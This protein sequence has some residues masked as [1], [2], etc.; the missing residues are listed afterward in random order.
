MSLESSMD[1]EVGDSIAKLDK[2][3]E[4]ILETLDDLSTVMS[5]GTTPGIIDYYIRKLLTSVDTH[6]LSE[7]DLM[8]KYNYPDKDKHI[9][10][11]KIFNQ[12][13]IDRIYVSKTGFP[14]MSLISLTYMKDFFK[15]HMATSNKELIT[16]LN[17]IQKE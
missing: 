11:H 1:E 16:F 12:F 17:N 9:A 3:H 13:V 5:R 10:E 2:D 7:Q 15:H 6:F 14:V 8:D 4:V